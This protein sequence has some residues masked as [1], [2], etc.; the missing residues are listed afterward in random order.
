[1]LKILVALSL[2]AASPAFALD[3]V[4]VERSNLLLQLIRDNGCSMTEE[5]AE[6]LLPENGFTKKEVGAILRAWET[7][8]WIAEMSDRGI[9]LREKSCTAG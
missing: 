7:A 8:D 5:L 6:T 3:I 2:L 1:M 4:D 9:T